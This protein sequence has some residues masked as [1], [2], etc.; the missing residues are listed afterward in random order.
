[1]MMQSLSRMV[2]EPG[3][4]YAKYLH[5][6]E[7]LDPHLPFKFNK[8]HV[9][10]MTERL[11]LAAKDVTELEWLQAKRVA[12]MDA[13]CRAHLRIRMATHFTE[14]AEDDVAELEHLGVDRLGRPLATD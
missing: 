12:R 7:E 14:V 6:L 9:L 11:S 13:V 1:M 5:P 10:E 3:V 2:P 4:P 8:V